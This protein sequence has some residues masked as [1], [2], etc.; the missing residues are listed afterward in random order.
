MK[1]NKGHNL[2]SIYYV[3]NKIIVSI[4][5]FMHYLQPFTSRWVHILDE[6]KQ[7]HIKVKWLAQSHLTSDPG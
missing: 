7:K 4:F 1:L 5:S 3:S 2:L 6:R